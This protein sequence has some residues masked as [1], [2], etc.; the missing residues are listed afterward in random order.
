MTI[1][2]QE[3]YSSSC[4]DKSALLANAASL[5]AVFLSEYQSSLGMRV[6]ALWSCMYL[7]ALFKSLKCFIMSFSYRA[8]I[9]SAIFEI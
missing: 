4:E 2:S 5:Y 7:V 6:D 9:I 3:D 1:V 8:R